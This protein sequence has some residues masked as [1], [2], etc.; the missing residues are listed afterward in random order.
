MRV[1][2]L[3]SRRGTKKE[4]SCIV[5]STFFLFSNEREVRQRLRKFMKI[6]SS[7]R[8]NLRPSPFVFL[9]RR[10]FALMKIHRMF[11]QCQQRRFRVL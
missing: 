7:Q 8:L 4:N 1:E 6:N 2:Y 10:Q 11:F 3:L 9:E 5:G